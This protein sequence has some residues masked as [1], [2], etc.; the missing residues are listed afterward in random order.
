M[1]G[2]SFDLVGT[3][4]LVDLEPT[5]GLALTLDP[6]SGRLIA[7]TGVDLPEPGYR[8]VRDLLP[9]LAQPAVGSDHA[10]EIVYLTY[11]NVRR[12]D[13]RWM[14]AHGLRYDL[15]VTLPGRI[16]EEL[17]KT[18]GHYHN[19]AGDGV[20]FPEIYD[21]VRGQAAFVLQ[22]SAGSDDV[23]D[24]RILNCQTGNRIVIPPD[25][26]HVTVNTGIEPLVVADLVAISSRNLYEAY[27]QRQGAAVYLLGI[28]GQPAEI[29]V[30]P[31]PNYDGDFQILLMHGSHCEPL[32]ASEPA[33][34][35]M[36]AAA[37]GRFE[38][39]NCPSAATTFLARVLV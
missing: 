25:W 11:R 32:I 19:D 34:Y 35:P 5:T 28:P 6:R 36:A 7:R 14:D 1:T 33:L 39:L 4:L 26:G 27:Q 29:Q 9:V 12:T 30:Q 38:F 22:Y 13:D 31:N 21:V 17:N 20:S 8:R 24:V 10:D 23:G 2:N 3:D 15:I 16:G 18:A 37:P